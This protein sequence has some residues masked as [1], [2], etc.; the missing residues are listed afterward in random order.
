MPGQLG[1][2]SRETHTNMA[3]PDI[4][5]AGGFGALRCLGGPGPATLPARPPGGRHSPVCPSCGP[6]CRSRRRRRQ[7][8]QVDLRVVGERGHGPCGWGSE[9]DVANQSGGPR[10][11]LRLSGLLLAQLVC[12]V[13]PSELARGRPQTDPPLPAPAP[14]IGR[15]YYE[16]VA[17]THFS[18]DRTTHTPATPG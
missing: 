8:P 5:S 4:C 3:F 13:R 14:P 18:H 2:A 1:S 17:R 6:Q 9:G 11:P 7:L 15:G 12:A 16:A 10:T